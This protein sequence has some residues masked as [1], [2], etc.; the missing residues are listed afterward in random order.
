MFETRVTELFG[1]KYPIIQGGLLWLARAELVAA[2]CNA[3]GLGIL[4]SFTFPT[5]GGLA[6][7]IAKTKSLTDKPFGVNIPLVPMIR[8][9]NIEEYF[10][11]VIDG[12]VKV[13]ETAGRSPEPFMERL[14][15]AGVK[16]IHK[17][18]AVRF[19]RTAQRI[20]CDAVI[21]DGFECAGH[22]GEEDVT[23]LILI[24]LTTD[25]VD[26]PVIAAGGFGDGRGFVAALALGA[27]AVLMG[28][29]FM[30]T[31][32]CLVHPKVREWLLQAT[33]RDTMLV[34]RSLANSARV[35]C[36]QYPGLLVIYT[37]CEH[38]TGGAVKNT[39]SG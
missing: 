30:A 39:I 25:A 6:E 11:V 8:P 15:G 16:V 14:K 17:V 18:T 3:G 24:P 19:A 2:V 9:V 13:V 36:H 32:E 31:Q 1:I 10:N 20:G 7:E 5:P 27:E 4:S 33:E 28:T 37:H 26:I 21:I 22:P 38:I 34:Q 29:R 35:E 12:G 23:S